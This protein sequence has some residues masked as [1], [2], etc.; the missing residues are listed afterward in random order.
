MRNEERYHNCRS[1][2]PD[3]TPVPDLLTA[4]ETI[5][6]LRLDIN[7]PKHPETTLQYY[8]NEGLLRGTQVGKNLRY[9]RSELLR[10][11]DVLTARR[12]QV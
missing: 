12:E 1:F 10:F 8:R 5:R 3:G 7:G 4:E 9:L 11:L 6:F 2:F